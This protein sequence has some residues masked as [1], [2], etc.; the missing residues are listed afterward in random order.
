MPA[1]PPN[2][3]NYYER[4]AMDAIRGDLRYRASPAQIL[5]L[6]R[7]G[8]I[9]RDIDNGSGQYKITIAGEEALKAKLRT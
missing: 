4:A 8:W 3:P 5:K 1:P 9:V 7:K 2:V 6:L